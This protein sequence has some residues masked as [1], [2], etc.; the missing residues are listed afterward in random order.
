M[1][2]PDLLSAQP[3]LSLG[4]NKE[5][6]AKSNRLGDRGTYSAQLMISLEDYPMAEKLIVDLMVNVDECY[7][8]EILMPK[9]MNDIYFQI[10]SK[11]IV[12][13]I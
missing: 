8:M 10:G 13:P 6:V 2:W 3:V 9:M 5:L 11:P 4:S 1:I 7:P 12:L